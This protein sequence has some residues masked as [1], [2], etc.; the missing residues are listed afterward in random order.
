MD[1]GDALSFGRWL[2]ARRKRRDLT[3]VELAQMVRC[4][5]GTLRNIEAD[6]ARPSKQLAMRLARAVGVSEADIDAVVAF[7]R[8]HGPAPLEADLRSA[9]TRSGAH[10]TLPAQLTY[11][12]GRAEEIATI[13]ALL[14]RPDV[15]L[16][17]LTG[18]GGIGKT[19]VAVETAVQLVDT[20][21]DGMLFVDLSALTDPALVSATIAQTAG[22][23]DIADLAIALRDQAR[24]LLL[25]NFE[26]IIAAAPVVVELLRACPSIKVLV[27]SRIALGVPG[28]YEWHIPPLPLPDIA[29]LPAFE[30][31]SQYESVR[32]FYERA[33]AANPAFTITS[34]NAPAIAEICSQLDGLP[35][36]I[37]LAA[38]RVKLFAPQALLARLDSRLDFLTSGGRL[39][40]TRQQTMRHTIT[41]SYQLL[42]SSQQHLFQRLG[43]FVNGATLAAIEVV[44][45]DGDHLADRAFEDVV[46]LSRSQPDPPSLPMPDAA[47]ADTDPRFGMFGNDPRV[48]ARAPRLNL[49]GEYYP[50]APCTLFCNTR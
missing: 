34:R 15:R 21:G 43:V 4:A 39:R 12:I 9:Q 27:T 17:T 6:D 14:E 11:L 32:L 13:R 24:L 48:R 37:E 20:F 8:G 31:L 33:R 46:A 30:Q 38:A 18:P 22:V 3:Q 42:T 41:W 45:G 49:R 35:L 47:D 23:P 36:A 16:V 7:A 26:Q 44:C 29:N 50:A 2:R 25:D 19:R 5:V 40:P 28:E 10:T 1:E